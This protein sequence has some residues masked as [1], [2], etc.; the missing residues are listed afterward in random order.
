[1]KTVPQ[2][3]DRKEA[4]RKGTLSIERLCIG[5]AYAKSGNAHNPT[6][7][8]SWIARDNGQTVGI[9]SSL[10]AAKDLLQNPDYK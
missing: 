6:P 8:Y 10:A 4:W 7:R 2:V 1:M 5:H 3:G 9:E